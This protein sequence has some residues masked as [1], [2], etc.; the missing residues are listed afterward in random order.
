M[1]GTCVVNIFDTSAVETLKCQLTKYKSIENNENVL[2]QAKEVISDCN[3]VRS[4][5][6]ND[7]LKRYEASHGVNIYKEK[8][9]KVWR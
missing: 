1:I 3:N 7:I 9:Q 6:I 4:W 5:S 8:F 2:T